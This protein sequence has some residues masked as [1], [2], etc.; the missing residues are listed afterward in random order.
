MHKR[1]MME[2]SNQKTSGQGAHR[3]SLLAPLTFKEVYCGKK[4]IRWKFG[5]FGDGKFG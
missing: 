5:F 4:N 1:A 2:G 3:F